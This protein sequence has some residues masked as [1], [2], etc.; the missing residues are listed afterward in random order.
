MDSYFYFYNNKN[1]KEEGGIEGGIKLYIPW[2]LHSEGMIGRIYQIDPNKIVIVV[3]I[4]YN[5]YKQ[6]KVRIVIITILILIN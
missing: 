5:K 1:Q 4:K 2:S 3:F 6:K